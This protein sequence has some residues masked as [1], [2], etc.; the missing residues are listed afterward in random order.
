MIQHRD[1]LQG[2]TFS[3]RAGPARRTVARV[4]AV[5]TVRERHV[6][7][8]RPGGAIGHADEH[9]IQ[10]STSELDAARLDELIPRSN[11]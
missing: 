11:D 6:R 3:T 7:N 8:I 2:P 9:H 5:D 4:H 1:A 10:R